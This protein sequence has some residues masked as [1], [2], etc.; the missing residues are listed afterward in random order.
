L[1][2]Y[3]FKKR[4]YDSARIPEERFK[5]FKKQSLSESLSIPWPVHPV[6]NYAFA[7]AITAGLF[8]SILIISSAIKQKTQPIAGRDF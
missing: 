5:I 1:I 3:N 6:G 8:F 7:F 4:R 2:S